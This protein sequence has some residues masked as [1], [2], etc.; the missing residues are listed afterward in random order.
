MVDAD[1]ACDAGQQNG[2]LGS[3]CTEMCT[4]TETCGDTIV[5]VGEECDDGDNI[6]GDGCSSDCHIELS[7]ECGNASV[8]GAEECDDGNDNGQ[9]GCENDCTFTPA[10]TCGN[11]KKEW[12]ELCD[13]GNKINNDYCSNDCI[14]VQPPVCNG[15]IQYEHCDTKLEPSLI[16]PF[17]AIGLGCESDQK[18]TIPLLKHLIVSPDKSAWRIASQFGTGLDD[19]QNYAYKP[20]EGDSF[21]ALSTGTISEPDIEGVITEGYNSQVQNGA[22][23]NPDGN[24]LPPG[25]DPEIDKAEVLQDFW[26]ISGGNPNDKILL[27]FTTAMPPEV[28]GYSLDF[29]FL[30]SEWPE[31]VDTPYN[32]LLLVWEVSDNWVGTVSEISG[33][34]TSSTSLHPHWSTTSLEADLSKNCDVFDSEGPGYSCTEPALKDTGFERHAGSTWLRINHDLTPGDHL[35]LFIFLADMGDTQQASVALIDNFR[36]RC[37]TCLEPDSPACLAAVPLSDCCGVVMPTK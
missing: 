10:G 27:S 18:I 4:I 28:K 5:Q 3:T 13:D 19:D 16:A 23:T 37:E 12:D 21:L 11:N 36:Y 35:N 22:N 14:P 15:A 6:S 17:H 7:E 25:I 8:E 1:E 31:W 33:S 26:Q 34:S 32:D 24:S 20:R 30:T 9:D 2:A 29:A